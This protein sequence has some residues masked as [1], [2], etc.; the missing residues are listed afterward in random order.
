[1]G[2]NEANSNRFER[3]DMLIQSKF[4]YI[5]ETSWE[6]DYGKNY[7]VYEQINKS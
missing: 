4:L 3:L 5:Q 1:M 6:N 7:A 2:M